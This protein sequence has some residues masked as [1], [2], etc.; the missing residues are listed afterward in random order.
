MPPATPDATPDAA[1][2]RFVTLEGGEGAGKTTHARRLAEA[3]RARG[4]EVVVTREPGGTPGGEEIRRLLVDGV[5]DRW[6]PLTE[7]LLHFA[8]RR[9]HVRR[10]I[11]PALARGAWVVS[12]RFTDSTMAYQGYGH[13]LG[14]APVEALAALTLDGLH[15]DLTLVLDLPVDEGLARAGGRGGAEARYERMAVAFH[16]RLRAG[17]LEIARAEPDRCVVIDARRDPDE[18]AG[19]ILAAVAERL[20]LP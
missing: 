11:R 7:A 16:E 3:L 18:V 4:P 9:E 1:P 17:F 2:G 12:D 15:P 19:A 14:R 20:G 10:C 13:G 8:A 6:D 5:A